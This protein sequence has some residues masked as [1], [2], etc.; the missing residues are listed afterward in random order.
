M[1][2]ELKHIAKEKLNYLPQGDYLDSVEHNFLNDFQKWRE[3][4]F[5]ELER[6]VERHVVRVF[7]SIDISLFHLA[8]FYSNYIKKFRT[9]KSWIYLIT[10]G[11]DP[12]NTTFCMVHKYSKKYSKLIIK[13]NVRLMRSKKFTFSFL[14]KEGR[15]VTV[16][17]ASRLLAQE[18]IIENE[19]LEDEVELFSKLDWIYDEDEKQLFT[20]KGGK[21][22]KQERIPYF[23]TKNLVPKEIKLNQKLKQEL[24]MEFDMPDDDEEI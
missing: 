15:I 17:A 13:T 19:Y 9:R 1:E 2:L 18:H 6:Y 22:V 7:Q 23:N 8:Y 11:S 3:I 24:Q 12:D 5:E 4:S 10:D 20:I 14:T 16:N 21:I